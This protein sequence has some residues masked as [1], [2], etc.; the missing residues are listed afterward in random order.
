MKLRYFNILIAVASMLLFIKGGEN[1]SFVPLASLNES[2]IAYYHTLF[3]A[4]PAFKADG[5]DFP[6]GK[7]NA[8]GYYVAQDFRANNH[9]G[10]DWNGRGGGNTDLGDPVYA[11]ADG[12]VKL[13]KEFKSGWGNIIRMVHY[14]EEPPYYIVESLYAHCDEIYVTKGQTVKRGDLIGTIGNVKGLYSAHL[15]LEMRSNVM[16]PIGTAYSKKTEGFMDPTDFIDL[17]RPK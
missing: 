9:L 1:E 7:P 13:A 6:V 11:I 2:E 4:N 17:H 14:L 3:N 12:Y 10:E 15:H 8:E 5:F 16:L